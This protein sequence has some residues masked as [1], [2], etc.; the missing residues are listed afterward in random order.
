M[1][2]QIKYVDVCPYCGKAT[3]I[4]KAECEHCYACLPMS[5]AVNRKRAA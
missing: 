3:N 1:K 5:H 4:Y 2:D